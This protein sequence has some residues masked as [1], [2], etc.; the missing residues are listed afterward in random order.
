MA[1]TGS[2]A[3]APAHYEH[4]EPQTWYVFTRLRRLE[5]LLESTVSRGK[6]VDIARTFAIHARVSALL[7]SAECIVRTAD[8][9]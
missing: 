3:E 4:M 8:A 9:A 5:R 7:E 6:N 2:G 1:A